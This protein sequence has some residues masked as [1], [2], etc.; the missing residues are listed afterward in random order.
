LK[1]RVFTSHNFHILLL[2]TVVASVALNSIRFEAKASPASN[3][4]YKF[5]VDR[6]GFTTV[7]INFNSTDP[8]GESWVFVPKNLS[9]WDYTITS[10]EITTFETVE[11]SRVIDYD[12]YFYRAF[13]FQYRFTELFNMTIRFDFDNGALIMEPHGIFYSPQIGFKPDSNGYA[14]VLFNQDFQ[15]KENRAVVVG[16]SQWYP[17]ENE[18]IEP[19]RVLF[20]L[21]ENVVRLQVELDINAEPEL[22]TLRSNDDMTFAFETVRRYEKYVRSVLRFYD[23]VY[24]QTARLFNATLSE[25]RVKWFLPDFQSLLTVGGY[26]PIFAGGLGEININVV[27]IRTVNGT[28]EV[29]AL[30]ELVHRFLD[31]VGIRPNDLLWFHEGMSQFVSVNLVS[32]LKY[33]GGDME[34]NNLETSS[35]QLIQRLGGEDFGS[36]SLQRWSPT[37]QPADIELGWL[38]AASYYVVSRLPEVVE[39]GWFEYYQSFFELVGQLSPAWNGAKIGNISELALYLSQAANKSVVPTLTERWGFRAADWSPLQ[40]L[41]KE[42]SKVVGGLNPVFQ[43]Y[44]SLADFAYQQALVSAEH[45]DWNSARSLL[46]LSITLANL[47][48]ILTFLTIVGILAL[49]VFVLSRRTRRPRSMVPPPPPEILQPLTQNLL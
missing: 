3:Y 36:I 14:E 48:P 23:K 38:Y 21:Q 26:I 8:S 9:Q 24:N 17:A 45:E 41:V 37:S 22:T 42:A 5:T 35:S 39:R 43:P 46:Q 32:S 20:P 6:E 12:I 2:L 13:I 29:I 1:I 25:V 15:I 11:T 10:G 7:E 40:D 18:N 47:A 33:E 28:V 27:F 34:K 16:G 49:L 4:Y 19:H 44:K 31:K 30:H